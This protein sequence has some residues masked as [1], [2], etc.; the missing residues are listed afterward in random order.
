M[1]AVILAFGPEHGR[2]FY[3]QPPLQ[4]QIFTMEDVMPSFQE[5]RFGEPFGDKK[6]SMM[7]PRHTY[8]LH[9]VFDQGMEECAIYFHADE[10]CEK[11]YEKSKDYRFKVSEEDRPRYKD[12]AKFWQPRRGDNR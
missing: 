12:P 7:N 1:I 5:Y 9:D 6:P 4:Q 8:A 11:T 3:V 10:C 2:T